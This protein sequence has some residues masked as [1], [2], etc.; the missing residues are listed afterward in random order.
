MEATRRSPE[1]ALLLLGSGEFEPWS[2]EVEREALSGRRPHVAVVPTASALEGDRVFD[3]WGA[4]AL[5]HYA[6]MGVA[7]E[8]VPLKTRADAERRDLAASI[9]GFGLVYFSGG[10]PRYLADTLRDTRFWRELLL[11]LQRGTAF[12]GCSAGAMVAS[13]LPGVR[14]RLGASWASGLGLVAGG[15]FGAHWDRMRFLPGARSLVVS[16]S[17]GGWFLGLDE[18]T[19]ILGDGRSW[20]VFGLGAAMLR[21]DGSTAVYRAGDRFSTPE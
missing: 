8:V 6:E 20:R 11:A 4:M 18:R 15:S 7:A 19:A 16:R 1:R 17:K 14:P 5:A 9:A 13:R 10:N 21:V 2:G 12:A 3:R